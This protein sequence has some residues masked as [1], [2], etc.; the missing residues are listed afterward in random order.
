MGDGVNVWESGSVSLR[1]IDLS[2]RCAYDW[3]RELFAD[4]LKFAV[5][6]RQLAQ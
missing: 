5:W 4:I 6:A 2:R 1:R 3:L